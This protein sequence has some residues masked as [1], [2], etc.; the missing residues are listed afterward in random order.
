VLVLNLNYLL[1]NL[2]QYNEDLLIV[3]VFVDDKQNWVKI[4][5]EN[6]YHLNE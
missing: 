2:D 5:G 3:E 4:L 1:L 6:I